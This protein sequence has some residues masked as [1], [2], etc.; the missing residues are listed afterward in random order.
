MNMGNNEICQRCSHQKSQHERIV[1]AQVP[2]SKKKTVR[3]PCKECDDCVN[4]EWD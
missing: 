3:S 2:R 4:S 1:V